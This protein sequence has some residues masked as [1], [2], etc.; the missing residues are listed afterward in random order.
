MVAPALI[1][2]AAGPVRVVLSPAAGGAIARF[3][4]ER[5]G[6]LVDVLRPAG[7]AALAGTNARALGSYPLVPFSNRIDHAGFRFD[8]RDYRLNRNFLPEPH[9]IHGD[10]WQQAW[11]VEDAARDRA[12][13]A[14][15]H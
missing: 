7:A 6:A 5:T 3:A 1:E 11:Q 12:T 13:L 15:R 14:Y 4:V 2:L 9:A 8:G 10:G